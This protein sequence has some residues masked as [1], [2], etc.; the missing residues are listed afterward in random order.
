MSKVKGGCGGAYTVT[1]DIGCSECE[2][3]GPITFHPSSESAAISACNAYMSQYGYTA[4]NLS[5]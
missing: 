1:F 3:T 2:T 5:C 4:Y